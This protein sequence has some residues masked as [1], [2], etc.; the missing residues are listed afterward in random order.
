MG[1]QRSRKAKKWESRKAGIQQNFEPYTYSYEKLPQQIA[2]PRQV[3]P[4][5]LSISTPC[6]SKTL[7]TSSWPISTARRSAEDPGNKTGTLKCSGQ[8]THKKNA[9][10]LASCS[11]VVRWLWMWFI[12]VYKPCDLIRHL[13]SPPF[14]IYKD[15]TWNEAPFLVLLSPSVKQLTSSGQSKWTATC[16]RQLHAMPCSFHT[17]ESCTDQPNGPNCIGKRGLGV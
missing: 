1:K 16:L 14:C 13:L 8:E 15:S 10:W 5:A 9:I 4:I 3:S 7:T 11:R 2:L 12:N 17:E 6:D